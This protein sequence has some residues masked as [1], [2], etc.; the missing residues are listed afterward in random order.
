M[1]RRAGRRSDRGRGPGPSATRCRC[2]PESWRGL[3]LSSISIPR[4]DAAQSIFC[5]LVIPGHILGLE[6]EGDVLLD[7]HVRVERVTLE[8]HGDFAG[9]G[10]QMGDGVTADQDI[11]GSRWLEPADHAQ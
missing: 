6:R 3:R 4:I 5:A 1:V 7:G 8:D 10:R 9:A 11:A 2:P